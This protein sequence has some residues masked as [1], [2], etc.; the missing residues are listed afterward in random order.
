MTSAA[1]QLIDSFEALTAQEKQEVLAQLLRRLTDVDY[2][3]L[4]DDALLHAADAAFQDYDLR[5]S[6]D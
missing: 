4:S 3:P 1:K 6:A 5:E 2:A